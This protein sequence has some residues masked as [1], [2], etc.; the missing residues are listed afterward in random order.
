M[1]R[2]K[3]IKVAGG[4]TLSVAA[5]SGLSWPLLANAS[6]NEQS[7]IVRQPLVVKPILVYSAPERR[8]QS[9]WRAWGGIQTEEDASDRNF[10]NKRGAGQVEVH[11][12][13]S[14]GL[15]RCSSH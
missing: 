2:R 11:I 13:F 15:F 4:T 5:L 7:G 9:S 14:C 12:G 1:S 3:F 6:L 8:H 10:K